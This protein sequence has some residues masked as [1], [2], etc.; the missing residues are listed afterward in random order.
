MH[1]NTI[2]D[3]EIILSEPQD[4]V[5]SC[6]QDVILDM[7]GQGSGKSQLIGYSSGM[8]ITEFPEAMGFIGANTVMQLSQSTLVRVFATW[9]E[10]YGYTEFDAKSNPGGAYVVDKKPPPHFRRIHKLK[11]YNGTISFY[12]GAFVFLGSLE[13]YM[14]HDGKQFA[15]AHLDETK[16]TKEEAV[17]QV[18]LARLR[19][20]GLW[21][22][23]T[24]EIVFNARISGEEAQEAGL[25]AWNPLYIHTSPAAATV[26]WL[27]KMFNLDSF[28]KEIKEKVLQKEKAFFY[29]EFQN[30]A[31]I[32]Y[33]AHHN[34]HNLPPNYISKQETEASD[35]DDLMRRVYGYPFA[36]LGGEWM[37]GFNREKHVKQVQYIPGESVSLTWDF[38]GFP[39]MTCLCAQI[40]Y[41]IRYLDETG[42]KY[43]T[44]QNIFRPIQVMVI[45][46]YREY[47]LADPLA[48]TEAVC[49]AFAAD[50]DPRI[51]EIMYYG[52]ASG[53]HRIPGLGYLTNFGIIK[54]KLE[55]YCHNDSQQVKDPNVY[56]MKRRDLCN[57][58]FSGQIPEIEIEIDEGME[59]TINDLEVV[60]VGA[61]GKI[62]TKKVDPVT[63]KEYEEVG[64]TS[65][66]LEYLVSEVCKDYII[67]E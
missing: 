33:S 8:L 56:P 36:K 20:Y 6:L 64:H 5:L 62:K 67:S 65:D 46:F 53:L 45:R 57:K 3:I 21:Y 39:Y 50:H 28:Q 51:T 54:E 27:N 22:S 42:K 58:I 12:N 26:K 66:A 25:T 61:K 59:K 43:L 7:A 55:L 60:K 35:E 13:N 10:V 19:Q 37:H 34:S 14:A 17:K 47:C 49:E 44:P 23:K 41:E 18:I 38:N 2:S 9:Q 4:A 52:D 29:K 31:V 1:P 11:D 24:K 48:S 15:W 63:K 40:R 16:D 30:K 32:I